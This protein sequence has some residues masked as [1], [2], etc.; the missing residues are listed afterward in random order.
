MV[1]EEGLEPRREVEIRDVEEA[2]ACGLLGYAKGSGA[3]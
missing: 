1:E 2:E 3:S